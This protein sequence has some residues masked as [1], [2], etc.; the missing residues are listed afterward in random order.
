M[1]PTISRN[2]PRKATL[3][4]S[5][6]SLLLILVKLGVG[7]STG[8]VVVLASAVDSLLDFLVS[9]FNAYAVHSAERPSDQTYNYGRGKMEGVAAFSEGLFILAS[10]LY[11]LRQAVFKFFTPGSL[12]FHL[13]AALPA[14]GLDWAMGSMAFSLAVTAALVAYLKR[15]AEESPS[16]IIRA[17]TLHYQTD[18]LSNGGILI[19]LL[20]IRLTGWAWVDPV[21]AVGVSLFVARAALPLLRKGLAMLLDR[22]LDESL[23]SSIRRIAESHSDR[24]TSVHE[25]KTRR[26]GDTNLVEF[27]LVFDEDIKL[28]EAHRIA[29]EIEMRVRDLEKGRWIINIHLDPVDDSYRDQRLAKQGV[30]DQE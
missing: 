27:H 24:V 14:A 28:R 9:S 16:L 19:A 23:V 4:A 8:A 5:L 12:D 22:A 15:R 29:D 11:I 30:E 10:A 3:V 7:F 6:A 21:I 25:L 26:S 17:D 20:L 2:A 18:L 13:P 1:D